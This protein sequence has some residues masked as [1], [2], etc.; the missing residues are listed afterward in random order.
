MNQATAN[1][2]QA[3]ANQT[4]AQLNFNRQRD[5]LAKAVSSR[6]EFDQSHANFDS[7]TVEATQGVSPED[8]IVVDPSD[9]LADNAKVNV[10]ERDTNQ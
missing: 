4:I 10:K 3:Q 9:S 8:R 1:L 5:L 2:A 7:T 6:Q